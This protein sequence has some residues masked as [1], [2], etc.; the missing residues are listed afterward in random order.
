MKGH[1]EY[2]KIWSGAFVH[3]G[4]GDTMKNGMTYWCCVRDLRGLARASLEFLFPLATRPLLYPSRKTEI[5]P[6]ACWW[7]CALE[8]PS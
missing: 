5:T 7:R 6:P 1:T 3:G 2:T 4:G 8:Y